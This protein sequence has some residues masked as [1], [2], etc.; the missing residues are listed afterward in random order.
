MRR[1]RVLQAERSWR[2]RV[3]G[4]GEERSEAE[5]LQP[6]KHFFNTH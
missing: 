2:R 1:L 3:T 4:L 5:A 6:E